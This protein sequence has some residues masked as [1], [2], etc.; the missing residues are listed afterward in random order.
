MFHG[1]RD[2][3]TIC[4]VSTPPG[5]GGISVVRMSG[6]KSVHL[7][8]K[9]CRSV[10]DVPETHKLYWGYFQNS[11]NIIDEVLVSCFLDGRSFTGEES[12]EISC[13]GNP[14]IC[15]Q[16]L[17]SLVEQGAR[18]A[19]RGE[20]T[21]RAFM[22]GRLDLVQ[23]ES[24]LSVITQQAPS[25]LKQASR[26]LKGE[27]SKYIEIVEDSLVWIMAQIEANIDFSTE[28]LEVVSQHAIKERLAQSRKILQDMVQSYSYGKILA[29]GLHVAL[30]GSPN[31]GKS[32]LINLLAQ[33]EKS[34]VTPIPG[35]TRDIIEAEILYKGQKIRLYD[36]AGIHD[37]PQDL[38]ESIGIQKGQKIQA[39]ADQV[40]YVY[41][42]SL[43]LSDDEKDYVLKI[44]KDRLIIVG[45]KVDLIS[46]PLFKM[47]DRSF[48]ENTFGKD[49]LDRQCVC[50]SANDVSSRDILLGK[51][52]HLISPSF[53][54]A[55]I[56]VIQSRH[57]EN[58]SKALQLIEN[59]QL[60]LEQGVGIEYVT[61][62]LMQALQNIHETLG[63]QFD[64]QIMDRVFKEFCIGK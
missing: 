9:F 15:Q 30:V 14:Q 22:N 29:E 2:L 40:L 20:F 27:L 26:Q 55:D 42:I 18:I 57:Y 37:K 60:S 56:V 17:N 13:H 47:E 44:G 41:D 61:V 35:T 63:R 54:Q 24:V 45:N 36:T 6:D 33:Q 59:A 1:D 32:T 39:E 64:D 16:I 21:Y 62:D 5:V 50:V 49:F 31:V 25:T 28:G 8:R 34:I 3:D 52:L 10:P 38:V 58:L 12:V 53:S 7:V 23:A 4:A 51:L 43:G 48:I 11:E 19:D 46:E